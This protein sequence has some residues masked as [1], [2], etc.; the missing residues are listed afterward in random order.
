MFTVKYRTYS[1]APTQNSD[2]SAPRCYSETELIY[3]PFELISKEQDEDGY[4]VIHAH[5]AGGDPGLTLKHCE[6]A[7]QAAGQP[8]APR[9]TAWVMNAN[10]AT[11]AKYDL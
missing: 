9:S 4:T 10:G 11:V 8:P 2:L 5:R 6:H 3:G 1:L 7:D